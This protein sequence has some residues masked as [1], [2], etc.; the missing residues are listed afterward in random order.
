MREYE[1]LIVITAAALEKYLLFNGWIRDY[2][3]KNKNMMVFYLDEDVVTFPSSEEFSD[4]YRILP[5][6][7]KVLAEVHNKDEKEIIKDVAAS[8]FDKIEF[9]IKSKSAE[10]GKLPLGYAA[11]CIEGLKELI[12]YSACAEQHKEP[13][14]MK[15]TSNAKELLNNFK[16]GQTEIGSFVINIDIQVV[17]DVNEQLTLDNTIHDIGV[18]HRVVKRIGKALKQVDEV[19]CNDVNIDELLPCAYEEGITAN[20]CDAFLK[21]KP[22]NEDVEVETKIRYA[23]SISRKTGD[24]EVVNLKGN[25][26]YVMNEISERYRKVENVDSVKVYGDIASLKKRKKDAGHFKREVI[27]NVFFDGGYRNIKAELT[28]E[29]YRVACDAHRDELQVEI[30]GT[31]DMGKKVWE[32]THVQNFVVMYK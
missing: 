24:V 13:V 11:K 15:T 9:R 28:D 2:E 26:F 5:K 29:D 25:H 18:E 14:C 23:S 21:L 32:F 6:V 30:E 16:L 10:K 7:I 31:L 3:F 20:M 17:D 1:N 27:V 19:I 22:E 8:Y 4:F 12:L